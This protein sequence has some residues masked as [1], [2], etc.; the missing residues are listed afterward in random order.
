LRVFGHVH[1]LAAAHERS[2]RLSWGRRNK[3]LGVG[4]GKSGTGHSRR[5]HGYGAV[6]GLPAMDV[7]ERARRAFERAGVPFEEETPREAEHRLIFSALPRPDKPRGTA[8]GG[9][10]S[11]VNG[12]V[13]FTD[14]TP[15]SNH[16]P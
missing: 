8:D 11:K 3:S 10:I 13:P 6:V 15:P 5:S 7:V 1:T 4:M 16:G 2:E 14:D 12:A 9:G